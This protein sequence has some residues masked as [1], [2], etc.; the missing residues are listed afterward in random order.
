MNTATTSE[1]RVRELQHSDV[2]RAVLHLRDA[3]PQ[4]AL[5]RMRLTVELQ[6][7]L[8]GC[9]MVHLPRPL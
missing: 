4:A 1:Q 7:L 5:E 6:A 9:G 2:R 8:E 3:E